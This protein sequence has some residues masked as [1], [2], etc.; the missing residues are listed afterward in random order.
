M[1]TKIYQ[2]LALAGLLS[3]NMA[4][5]AFNFSEFYFLGDSLSDV[6]NA[7]KGSLAP[8]TNGHGK[9]WANDLAE[10][11]GQEIN[12]SDDGGTDYAYFG[13]DTDHV[14]NTQL[15]SLLVAHPSLNSKALYSIWAGANDLFA[16][17]NIPAPQQPEALIK[18]TEH[19]TDNLV[20]TLTELHNHGARY[21]LLLN[22]PDLGLV[23]GEAGNPEQATAVAKYFNSA[24]LNKINKLPFDVIQLDIFTLLGQISNAEIYGFTNVKD[25]CA[26][27]DDCPGYL[28][29]DSVHPTVAGHKIIG[30]Y[31]ISVLTAPQFTNILSELPNA[32]FMGQNQVIA[33]NLPPRAN[34]LPVGKSVFFTG[35][36]YSNNKGKALTTGSQTDFVNN[37]TNLT[38]GILYGANE[39][40]TLGAAF[41][42]TDSGMSY[43]PLNNS[44]IKWHTKLLSLF[45]N[46]QFSKAYLNTIFSY[47]TLNFVDIHRRFY[48]GPH[49]EDAGARA[50]G[51]VYNAHMDTGY[52]LI[53]RNDFTTGP[54]LNVDYLNIKINPYT[55]QGAGASNI[56]YNAQKRDYLSS[57]L[58]WEATLKSQIGSIDSLTRVFIAGN[59]QWLDGN[60]DIHFH[61]ASLPGSHGSLPV[62]GGSA[63]NYI[64]TG[65]S[66]STTLTRQLG[67]SLGY[68]FAKDNHDLAQ[69]S[70]TLNLQYQFD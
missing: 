59:R 38:A 64:S 3:V 49:L 65:A 18:I 1:K 68:E 63:G 37:N 57:T 16:L 19:G 53:S 44:S 15:Q 60:R 48:L 43:A 51:S 41:G 54:Y 34:R 10:H 27:T 66:I 14:V 33:Q 4:S 67:L 29:F 12:N 25:A 26:R 7:A 17:E 56:A 39:A 13:K 70:V 9:L 20:T 28:F 46:Y 52:Q 58:G 35:G 40:L 8:W 11:Y 36:N 50:T 42:Y 31:A 23:P 22:I 6:G 5:S 2:T 61:V 24:L 69:H 55:E 30:D 32:A 47:G 62:E 21:I 45:A